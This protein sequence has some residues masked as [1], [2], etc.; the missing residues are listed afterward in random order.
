M[1]GGLL[2][3]ISLMGLAL[4]LWRRPQQRPAAPPP[5]NAA[6]P[7]VIAVPPPVIAAPPPVIAASP[8]GQPQEE[9]TEFIPRSAMKADAPRR[10][11]T[12]F[13]QRMEVN[14]R[15][16]PREQTEPIEF[17][18]RYEPGPA[19]TPA[20]DDST[21][22]IP[23]EE[24][25]R[26]RGASPGAGSSHEPTVA[27][28]RTEL[29]PKDELFAKLAPLP[30]TRV[31]DLVAPVATLPTWAPPP[32]SAAPTAAP[33]VIDIPE[34]ELRAQFDDGARA[35]VSYL[36]TIEHGD[37]DL[38]ALDEG[39]LRKWQG[40]TEV[41]AL[42]AQRSFDERLLP[43]LTA[44]DINPSLRTAAALTGLEL[45]KKVSKGQARILEAAE[46]LDDVGHAAIV[47]AVALWDDPGAETLVQKESGRSQG[48][49]QLNWLR[50]LAELGV[51]PGPDL[52]A[53]C[54]S[55]GSPELL[56]AGIRLLPYF[57]KGAAEAAR[58]DRHLFDTKQPELRQ[59]AIETGLFF[60]RQSAW[61]ICRQIAHD[62]QYPRSCELLALLG[63]AGEVESLIAWA[64][65]S[66]APAHAAWCMGLTGRV[67]G[68]EGCLAR[69][70]EAD[71]AVVEAALAGFDAATGF[72]GAGGRLEVAVARAWW[73]EHRS[74]FDSNRRYLA[75]GTYELPIVLSRLHKAP[76][77]HRHA[78]ALELGLRSAGKMR[79]RSRALARVQ[80]VQ[81]G[82]VAGATL[83]FESGFPWG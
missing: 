80:Q 9:K 1:V 58:L 61:L 16:Q 11:S 65:K 50:L 30:S 27:E 21:A 15:V 53:R 73:D 54:L 25:A 37:C 20:G 67:A 23:T 46:Q 13:M 51:D 43:V 52:I 35:L 2:A 39:L 36:D 6:P 56:A 22:F 59:S 47:R 68:I 3:M 17:I 4:F 29:I 42:V 63:A 28:P 8:S 74:K 79:V 48:P 5:V 26:M 57:A 40:A 49:H 7:P 76:A 12:E 33:L 38:A 64:V 18:L 78:L 44:R 69:M 41:L 70:G 60:R 24:I 31:H 45:H 81:L 83:A 72:A 55:A 10:K 75:G 71:A 34:Q 82:H 14:H 66:T 62:P 77:R 19:P 32:P